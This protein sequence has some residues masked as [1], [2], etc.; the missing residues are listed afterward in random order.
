MLSEREIDPGAIDLVDWPAL[1]ALAN[2][3]SVAPVLYSRLKDRA[4]ALPLEAAAGLRESYLASA[5]RNMRVFHELNQIL[6]AFRAAEV[7]VIPIKGAHLARAV[8]DDVA[9]RQMTDIDLWVPRDQ[10]ETARRVMQSLG[11]TAHSKADRPQALQDALAGETQMFKAGATLVELH[12]NIFPGEWVRHTAKV[13]EQEV[14]DRS[15]PFDGDAERQLSPE[16]A[17]VHLCVHLAVNHQMSGI[18][19]RTLVDLDRARQKWSVDWKVVAQRARAWRVSTAT[20]IVLSALAELFGDPEKQLPLQALAPSRLRQTILHRFAA[21]ERL[22]SGLNLS[23]GPR[24]FL[25]LLALV[26]RPADAIRLAWRA[27]FPDR[28]WLTLRYESPDASSW[29]VWRLR[30]G[31]LVNVATRGDV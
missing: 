26:D 9:L 1:V 30:F 3:Q 6:V 7:S 10:L 27:L 12:W 31:H 14:W 29:L 22:A 11:Y 4:A 23:A 2:R 24:R 16:D 8:Y 15:I 25:F 19:L 21:P 13:D 28:V 18:G 5:A 17:I 20:W